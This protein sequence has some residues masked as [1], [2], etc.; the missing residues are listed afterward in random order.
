MHGDRV[1]LQ[2]MLY[3][4]LTQEFLGRIQSP[5]LVSIPGKQQRID[6]ATK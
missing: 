1:Q 3:Q 6:P 5:R 2:A 4:V